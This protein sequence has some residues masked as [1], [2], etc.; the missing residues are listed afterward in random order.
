MTLLPPTQIIYIANNVNTD[1]QERLKKVAKYL[2]IDLE[3]VNN[4]LLDPRFQKSWERKKREVE[5]ENSK[6]NYSNVDDY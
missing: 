1:V 6:V 2:S 5:L 3:I 4:G